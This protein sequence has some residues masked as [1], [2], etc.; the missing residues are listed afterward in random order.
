MSTVSFIARPVTQLMPS[1]I[2]ASQSLIRKH[3]L[4]ADLADLAETQSDG[5]ISCQFDQHALAEQFE[6]ITREALASLQ[7]DA[8]AGRQLVRVKFHDR[9]DRFEQG[10]LHA[11]AVQIMST[12]WASL[13]AREP[14]FT[15]VWGM[16]HPVHVSYCDGSQRWENRCEAIV[17]V[18][19]DSRWSAVDIVKACLA[20]GSSA[21][22]PI[23][24][25]AG[26]FRTTNTELAEIFKP[27]LWTGGISVNWD[28][29]PSSLHYPSLVRQ[30]PGVHRRALLKALSQTSAAERVIH[31]ELP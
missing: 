17:V 13:I 22:A 4:K 8:L 5:R 29:L 12:Y 23:W 7:R 16:S 27:M 30:L 26:Q 9:L 14:Q 10:A 18:N 2:S 1:A 20:V 6:S 15:G 25:W 28:L 11:D 31:V 21:H 24:S 3:L 19:T